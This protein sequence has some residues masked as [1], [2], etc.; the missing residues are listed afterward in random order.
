MA[1][2]KLLFRFSQKYPCQIALTLLLGLAGGLFNGVST[3]LVAPILLNLFN[4][5]IELKA[6]PPLIET[7]VA[8][9]YNIPEPYRLNILLGAIVLAIVL[10]NLTAYGSSLV[11]VALARLL[12][13]D[14]RKAGLQMLLDVDLDFYSRVRVGDLIQKLGEETG[15]TASALKMALQMVVTAITVLI[16]LAILLSISWKLTL[17]STILLVFLFLGNQYIIYR[18]KHFGN[19]LSDVSRQYSIALLEVLRGIRLVKATGNETEEFKHLERL[20]QEREKRNFQAQAHYLM[21]EPLNEVSSVIAL[22]L[23]IWLGQLF[24]VQDL[25][26]F[27]A[28]LLVYLLVLL[29]LLPMIGVLNRLR[30]QCASSSASINMVNSFLRLDDKPCMP[31]GSVPYH[32]LQQGICFDQVSFAYPAN[33]EA[34]V[35]KDINLF[36]PQGTT[37]A[38]VG[39]SGVGKSTLADLLPRFYDPT[40]GVI[41]IDGRDLREFDLQSLRQSMG[42][43]CQDTFLF[44]DSVRNNIRYGRKDATEQEI[45]EAATLAN[46][47]EFIKNLPQGL[48]T[49][50]GDRGVLLSGGQRQRLAIA[51]ALLQHPEILILDEATSGLDSLSERLVQSAIDNLRQHRT[52]LV[53]AHRLST[54]QTADQIAVIASG[55]VVEIGTHDQ[56]LQQNGFY[57]HLY[58]MQFLNSAEL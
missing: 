45:I 47:Y 51:R 27:S 54:I 18:S 12:A 34:M 6:V 3:T 1:L 42:I 23:L 24:F 38:L 49:V 50:I 26:V 35:L 57:A 5:N 32:S 14:L 39:E 21:M 22:I 31:N 4:Q 13:A 40:S 28:I 44:H 33:P 41:T 2:I 16:F 11:S 30:G 53:I 9:F 58:A 48:D 36:L 43:V 56:L 46:A 20:V 25:Q 10:K 8:P 52:T 19:L 17:L 37:L 29:R 15:R 7:I 55:Q